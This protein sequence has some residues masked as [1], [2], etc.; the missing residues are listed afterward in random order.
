MICKSSPK[1]SSFLSK[2]LLIVSIV[3]CAA[4]TTPSRAED[5][6]AASPAP[7][8]KTMVKGQVASES[9]ILHQQNQGQ[10][11]DVHAKGVHSNHSLLE[12]I[13]PPHD[14][15][16]HGHKI[17]WLFNYTT[18]IALIFFLIMSGALAYF[19]IFNRER[20]GHKAV[21]S[22]GTERMPVLVRTILVILVFI[23]LDGVLR[24]KSMEFGKDVLWKMPNSAEAVKIMIM[25]QQWAWNFRYAGKDGAF[26][27]ADDIVML[28]EMVIPKGRP[29]VVQILSKD[30]IHGFF[31][32]NARMQIDAIPGQVSKMW[33]DANETGH[34]EIACLHLCGTAHYKMKAFLNVMEDADYKLWS[35]ENSTWAAAKFDPDDKS[36][37][38]GWD[39]GI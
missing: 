20:P 38:W 36:I 32:P 27:T 16:T 34:F 7:A 26:N 31:V 24:E 13:K 39:W 10:N 5:Q 15:S 35:E 33:F 8:A 14:F 37:Q 1:S 3:A 29:I 30:V 18:A 4:L 25:P 21:Y 2:A 12:L 22:H 17:D 9:D 11:Q 28:N 6:Q 23:S 19:L